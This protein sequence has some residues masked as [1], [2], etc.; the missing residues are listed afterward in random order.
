M[1]MSYSSALVAE[2]ENPSL[3]V[4]KKTYTFG[5]IMTRRTS[6]RKGNR[7]SRLY[8]QRYYS[9]VPFSNPALHLLKT[10]I[11]ERRPSELQKLA[12]QNDQ[13]VELDRM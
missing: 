5:R 4:I 3:K 11:K 8:L 12:H 2:W 1:S 10:K 7:I 6:G 13:T 9:A